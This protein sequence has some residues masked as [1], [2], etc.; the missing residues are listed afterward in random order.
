MLELGEHMLP[1][2]VEQQQNGQIL[3][4]AQLGARVIELGQPRDV[5]I[6]F[7]AGSESL[8]MAML[9]IGGR[10]HHLYPGVKCAH[11]EGCAPLKS[12][13]LPAAAVLFLPNGTLA[14][15]KAK[16]GYQARWHR[17]R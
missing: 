14:Q 10:A 4:N 15:L 7:P 6:S 13:F 3:A 5:A 9:D 1:V 12:G 16:P 2:K 17:T 11:A 8:D